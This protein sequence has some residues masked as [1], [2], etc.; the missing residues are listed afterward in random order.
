[1]YQTSASTLILI[2]EREKKREKVEKIILKKVLLLE[3]DIEALRKELV[4]KKTG[5]QREDT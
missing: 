2:R 4:E 1:L 5:S 3:E